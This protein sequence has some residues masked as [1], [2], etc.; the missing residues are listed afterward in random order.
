MNPDMNPEDYLPTDDAILEMLLDELDDPDTF[1]FEHIQK[2][3]VLRFL[4]NYLVQSIREYIVEDTIAFE[5]LKDPAEFGKI[6]NRITNGG[7]DKNDTGGGGW[8]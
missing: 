1:D 5:R 2:M 6:I 3:F 4:K 8:N 7:F